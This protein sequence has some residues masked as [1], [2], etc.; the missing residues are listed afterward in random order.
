M[1]AFLNIFFLIFHTIFTLFNLTGWISRKTRRLHLLTMLL[2]AGSWFILGIWYGWGFC[3]CTE[4]HWEVRAH[5]GYHD[6]PRSYIS[7]LIT[8]LTGL[9]LNERLVEN[10]TAIA[11]LSCFLLS[12]ILNFRD[13]K[14]GKSGS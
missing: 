10:G 9:H 4:W 6:M 2:T 3:F 11:F 14:S 8:T 5:L 13:W 1:Y 7:F 12:L